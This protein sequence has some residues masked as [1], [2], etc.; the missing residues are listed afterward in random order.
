MVL[1]ICFSLMGWVLG[2]NLQELWRAYSENQRRLHQLEEDARSR[3][4]PAAKTIGQEP[5][6]EAA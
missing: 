4:E 2:T 5:K 1:P 3:R 6:K